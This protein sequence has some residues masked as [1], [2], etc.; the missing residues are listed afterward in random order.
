MNLPRWKTRL[1]LS[2][3]A[4]TLLLGAQGNPFSF[5][6]V[7]VDKASPDS[8][9][10]KS[11]AD[12]NGDKL[13]DL[14]ISGGNGPLVWYQAPYWVK[15]TIDPS[16]KSQSGSAAVDID[17]DGDQDL[18]VGVVLYENLNGRGTSWKRHVLGNAGTHDIAVADV[19]KDGKLDVVMRGETDTVITV[20]LQNAKDDWRPFEVDPRRSRNGLDVG[21]VDRDGWPDLVTGSV[22]MKNPGPGLAKAR[23]SEHTYTDWVPYAAVVLADVN[24]DGR[25]DVVASPSEEKGRVSWLEA[26]ADPTARWRE[27]VIEPGVDSI[28][29]LDVL[30]FDGDGDLDVVGSEF[31]GQK[32]LFVWLNK[33]NGWEARVLG[34]EGLHQTR[35]ADAGNDG[36]YDVFGH[37]CPEPEACFGT[38]PVVLM[39]N[40][41]SR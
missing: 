15:R 8:A 17:K 29:S 1:L 11:V 4:L 30:D 3:L 14:V 12:L 9:W 28:H 10:I 22:W 35:V 31:R 32:R 38:G 41:S 25:L 6:R 19:D 33:G 21:D 39:E 36:D 34:T 23:W 18:V 13:P 27:H 26:P 37:V 24:G 16:A 7:Q 40:R 2:S 5:R 20:F